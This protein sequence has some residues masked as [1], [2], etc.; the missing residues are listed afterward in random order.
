MGGNVAFHFKTILQELSQ[1]DKKKTKA[2]NWAK[3]TKILFTE[4]EIEILCKY[5]KKLLIS[6]MMRH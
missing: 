3:A 2:E 6:F 5:A 4:K 1:F